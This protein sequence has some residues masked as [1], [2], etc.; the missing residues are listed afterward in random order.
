MATAALFLAATGLAAASFTVHQMLDGLG[1]EVDPGFPYYAGR[2]AESIASEIR[3]NG[4][5]QVHYVVT[6]DAA[7]RRDLIDAFH[8][9]GLPVWYL[10]FCHVAYSTAD[11]PKGW[12]A[13]K[14]SLRNSP[15]KDYTR[16]CMNNPG[17]IAFKRA[18]IA[19]SMKRYPF[20]GVELVEPFWPDAPG[21]S[22][23]TYGCLCAHCRAAFLKDHP[24][25]T[26]MPEFTDASSPRWYK[27]N[28]ELYRKWMDSR[29]KGIARFLNATL[30][31]PGGVRRRRPDVPTMV[32]TLVQDS[33]NAVAA[34]RE[35]QGNDAGEMAHAVHPSAVCL[36]T[37]WMDWSRSELPP[38]YLKKYA[39]FV[40]H[41]RD[42]SPGTAFTFQVDTGS[43][44][45]SR[46]TYTW[47]KSADA[48]ARK[49]GARGTVNY[50]Y[51]ITKSMYDDPPRLVEA[52]PRQGGVSLVFQ[53][54]VDAGRASDAAN[55]HVTGPQ[56]EVVSVT[57]AR[58]DGNMI[59]LSVRGLKPGKRYRVLVNEMVDTPSLWLFK[60]YPGHTVRGLKAT[61]RGQG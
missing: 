52:R 15:G 42:L 13:W 4:Y 5:S 49:M 33:P 11:F 24:E 48:T 8:K 7:I 43:L 28:P 46:Q 50:E 58:A 57:K 17:Y 40:K 59:H 44:A 27:S 39:P 54:R 25:E 37:N 55:Y 60:G 32:W 9:E 31:G 2:S 23:D 53:K 6:N 1:A 12:E 3:A 10:T 19:A 14:M 26:A 34:L 47:L 51:F 41:L 38:D 22:S 35:A 21:P 16:L 30:D 18:R 20:D 56:G 61:F 36:Q 29:V 45:P